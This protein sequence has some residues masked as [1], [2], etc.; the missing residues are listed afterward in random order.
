[1]GDAHWERNPDPARPVTYVTKAAKALNHDPRTLQK[2]IRRGDLPGGK[3]LAKARWWVYTDTAAFRELSATNDKPTTASA[4]AS[5]PTETALH[6]QIAELIALEAAR[7]AGWA[8]REKE[9]AGRDRDHQEKIRQL[10]AASALET[11]RAEAAEQAVKQLANALAAVRVLAEKSGQLSTTYRDLLAA[12][13]IPDDP[14]E[15][16]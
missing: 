9:W 8:L 12:N 5:P 15:L 10:M 16:T 11:E 2:K 13:Y 7:E 14:G 6:G 4:D 1:M 3:Y